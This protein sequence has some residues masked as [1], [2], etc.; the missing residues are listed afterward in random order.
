[1]TEEVKEKFGLSEEYISSIKNILFRHPNIERVIIFGSRAKGNFR[2]GSDIDLALVGK[3]LSASDI[4]DLNIE[5]D[6]IWCGYKVDLL[7]YDKITEQALK[8]HINRVGKEF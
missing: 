2:P 3:D 7:I 5:L 1:M 6:K 4:I 8:E